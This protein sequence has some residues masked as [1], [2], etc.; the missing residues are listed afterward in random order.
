L[1]A[2]I[3]RLRGDD[4]YDIQTRPPQAL[5]TIRAPTL[6]HRLAARGRTRPFRFA[7][8]EHDVDDPVLLLY[9]PPTATR[10][11]PHVE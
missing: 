4:R 6:A 11:I 5:P 1:D 10:P 7:A 9:R 2:R 3:Q 8:P